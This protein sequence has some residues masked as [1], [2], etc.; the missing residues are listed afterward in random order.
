MRIAANDAMKQLLVTDPIFSFV[1]M[2]ALNEL[3]IMDTID[4]SLLSFEVTLP[5]N[6]MER[7]QLL[8][9]TEEREE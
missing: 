5:A 4:I 9:L 6:A 3:S 1:G 2:I 8:Y 7:A